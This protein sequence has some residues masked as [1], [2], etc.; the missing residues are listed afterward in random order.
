M[1]NFLE[2]THIF[3]PH[4]RETDCVLDFGCGGGFLLNGLY[5]AEKHG[6]DVNENALAQ[7]KSFGIAAHNSYDSIEN[8]KFDVI[9]SD[10]A[11]EHTP[12]PYECLKELKT[13]LK[14]GGTLFFRVPHE[15]LA[16]AYQEGDW[17]YHL[18]TWSPMAIGNLVHAAGYK[19]ISVAIEKGVRPPLYQYLKH[20]PILRGL[21]VKLYRILR[22]VI[23]EL[24]VKRVGL[25]GY[26]VV[27][28]NHR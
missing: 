23:E 9:I 19:N 3:S 5:C 1:A 6:F 10:S 14:S 28:A 25:D 20:I 26:A 16:W 27:K 8:D 24:G 2:I 7:V 18:F 15:T 4:I 22:L 11:R 12:N 13:K 21:S 17:N